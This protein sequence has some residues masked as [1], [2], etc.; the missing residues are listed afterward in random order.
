M[1][2]VAGY[3][4]YTAA[5]ISVKEIFA[6]VRPYGHKSSFLINEKPFSLIVYSQKEETYQKNKSFFFE[7]KEEQYFIIAHIHNRADLLKKLEFDFSVHDSEILF[8]A[9]K[10]QGLDGLRK[11]LGKWMM[12]SYHKKQK[13]ITLIRDHLGMFNYY[14]SVDNQCFIFS[15]DIEW[16][17]RF[18]QV[19]NEINPLF[20]AG[21]AVGFSGKG[22]E[23][24]YNHVFKVNPATLLEYKDGTA[25]MKKY[26]SPS[27]ET[28]LHYKNKDDYYQHFLEL[29]NTIVSESMQNAGVVASTLSSGLD[30][31]FVTALAAN[32]LKN[33]NKSLIAITSSPKYTNI[34]LKSSNR[35]ADEIPLAELVARKYSNIFHI[36]DK[37]YETDPIDGLLKSLDVHFSPVRNA[38]NQYWLFSMFEK[39][40][41]N[42]VDTLLIGQMGNLTY[43][44]PFFNPIDSKLHLKKIIKTLLFPNKPF[45]IKNSYLASSFLNKYHVKKYLNKLN[46]KPDFHSNDLNV[47]RHHFFQQM[48]NA[49]YAAWNE[50]ANYYGMNVLDP[51]ADVR[52]IEYCFSLP[53][54]LFKNENGNRQ[55]I[56]H[57]ARNLVPNEILFNQK[58][59][60]QSADASIRLFKEFNQYTTLLDKALKNS[61]VFEFF[62]VERI[63]NS[64]K[65]KKFS[66]HV[67]LRSLLIILFIY[68]AT[69]NSDFR[70]NKKKIRI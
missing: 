1:Y 54:T 37:A 23:T 62:D 32:I 16:L 57:A 4:S 12:L 5:E 35:Y 33:Q 47:M 44:W 20:L 50:K 60:I 66:T 49:G 38:G 27:F 46:Y 64:Y 52:L 8:V 67:F 17:F 61:H 58:K 30:S 68:F 28:T 29:F 43:S 59:A 26:W 18:K 25:S 45:Y 70:T 65:S 69:N 14:Y 63:I 36:I 34:S 39:L 42:N 3:I 24:A 11:C 56:R 48:Q 10:K 19:N 6:D 55:F 41:E 22:D 21:L 40:K 51:T 7:D 13:K 15:T 9:Y 2:R 53:Q 31:T